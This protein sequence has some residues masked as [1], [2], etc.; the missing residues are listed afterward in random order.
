MSRP[1]PQTIE[2]ELTI[3]VDSSAATVLA[4]SGSLFACVTGTRHVHKKVEIFREFQKV[5]EFEVATNSMSR[6]SF[7]FNSEFLVSNESD[8][9][10]FWSLDGRVIQSIQFPANDDPYPVQSCFM[11]DGTFIYL[12]PQAEKDIDR[13]V[14]AVWPPGISS[15]K[16]GRFEFASDIQ[17]FVACGSGTSAGIF[18]TDRNE[19]VFLYQADGHGGESQFFHL[20]VIDGVIS[21]TEMPSRSTQH[22]C[23]SPSNRQKMQA[24]N[25]SDVFEFGQ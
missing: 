3:E 18:H 15:D 12:G 4:P 21:L 6:W 19:H 22:I 11:P 24:K 8:A 14:V 10:R 23:S 16:L 17:D 13:F 7:S 2:P 9:V 20:N 1:A 5:N 25:T